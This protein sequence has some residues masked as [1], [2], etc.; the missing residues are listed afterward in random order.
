MKQFLL[1]RYLV[2]TIISSIL[3]VLTVLLGMDLFVQFL[4]EIDDI[5][6]GH[7]HLLQAI[8]VAFLNMPQSVYQFF[9]M[10]GLVGSLLAL[11]N[12]AQNSE[13][14]VMRAAGMSVWQIIRN[15]MLAAIIMMIPITF[16]G[17]WIAPHALQVATDKKMQA[18]S[19][20]QVL[21]N[22]NGSW[23]RDNNTFIYIRAVLSKQELQ[24]IHWYHLNPR[25]MQV[26]EIGV[27]ERAQFSQ[28]HWQLIHANITTLDGLQKVSSQ[29]YATI[30]W[31]VN[32]HP[33][34]LVLGNI[35]PDEMNL[36]QLWQY[37]QFRRHNNLQSSQYDLNFWQ[38]IL[39]PF[40]SMIMIL[41]A[42]PFIFG[43]LRGVTMGLRII[44]GVGMGILFYFANQLFGPF[45][46]VYQFPAFWAAA[47]PIIVF[48][49]IGLFLLRKAN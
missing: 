38:R 32:L 8:G 17:E 28:Q 47:I 3:L 46:M 12:L 27:A 10:A 20:G 15:V 5:G 2:I 40:A 44:T 19:G 45:S 31:Q 26:D 9:P 24:G 11:G 18:I 37:M 34:V 36:I 1:T 49:G 16:L 4:N 23:V 30:S 48:A 7:Y 14:I 33:H 42:V 39:Q 35:D 13:L 41:L 29:Q 25:N 21:R 43:P 6:Q 22:L